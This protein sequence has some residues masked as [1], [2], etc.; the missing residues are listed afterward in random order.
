MSD[1]DP[2]NEN[3]RGNLARQTSLTQDE[4]HRYAR[5]LTL[6]QVGVR[7]QDTLKRSSVL[8]V[9]AGGLGSPVS[10]YLAAAGV[11]KIGLVDFD[12][13]DTTNLQRQVL[14]GQ[15]D[16][17]ERKVEAAK[18][19]LL[20]LNPH[21]EVVTHDTPLTSE[22]ALEIIPQYD[23]VADGTDNFQTRYLVN[24]ACVLTGTPNAYGSIFRF[25][26]QASVFA[27][28]DGPC[29]RCLYPEPPPPGL[30]PSCAEGGVLGVL[31][32][33]VGCI[34]AT[35]AIKLLLKKGE[36]LTGRLLLFDALDMDFRTVR[37]QKNPDCPV[38]GENPT[39]TKLIDYNQFCGI[40]PGHGPQLSPEHTMSVVQLR[41]RR[42]NGQEVVLVDVR[43]PGEVE[44]C[45]LDDSH[46]IPLQDLP[47]RL[48]EIPKDRPVVLMC[49]SGVR[50]AR[51]WQILRESGYEDIYNLTGGI[52]AWAR[53]IDP[54]MPTY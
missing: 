21:I 40:Q 13:V 29:Y 6:P 31:P 43:E 2:S 51:A 9:G 8:V 39:V 11:G 33:I 32:G 17:G 34:Q 4:L 25:E 26:G 35:E 48:Q 44:V 14:Y 5:H 24:D 20:D 7:G 38:C 30:V 16:V 23:V 46:N 10:L 27:N 1:K 3:G 49:R 52:L 18:K 22:N 54:Q 12:Q 50:S 19:R 42:D 47:H 41:D 28:G 45:A 53:E 15:S 36:T 37:V